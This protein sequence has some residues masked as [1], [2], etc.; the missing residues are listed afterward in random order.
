MTPE[1]FR[2]YVTD[3]G[4]QLDAVPELDVRQV[5]PDK[6]A[7]DEMN[8]RR[9]EPLATEELEDSIAENGVVEPPVCRVRDEDARRPYTVVQGQRRVAAAQTVGVDTI[10]ILIGEFDDKTALIRSITENVKSNRKEVTTMSRAAAIWQLWKLV[11]EE[12]DEMKLEDFKYPRPTNIATLLGVPAET[13]RNW[14][15]PLRDEFSG[16]KIDVRETFNN[17]NTKSLEESTNIADISPEKLRTIREDLSG[18]GDDAFE[19]AKRVQEEGLSIEDVKKVA[20]VEARS[21]EEAIET[22]KTA[23]KAAEK[24]EGYVLD[25]MQFGTTTSEGLAKATRQMGTTRE[26]VVQTAVK[27]F[28]R[29]EGFL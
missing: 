16:S 6:I 23:K 19:V 8:E 11:V 21:T 14:I 3:G 9:N 5:D 24:T 28:L 17:D 27:N 15:E 20:D 2:D 10:P 1:Q 25:Q 7:V 26:Q 22:V 4:Q 18:G 13:A 29:E 12:D